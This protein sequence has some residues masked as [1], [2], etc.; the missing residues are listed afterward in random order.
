MLTKNRTNHVTS[1]RKNLL[2]E[3]MALAAA[4][5]LG[6]C[7][8]TYNPNGGFNAHQAANAY[9][10]FQQMQENSTERVPAS[11]RQQQG[12]VPNPNGICWR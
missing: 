11:P 7:A 5:L 3:A 1:P 6:G 9:M 4:L 8:T 12:C 10:M 2:T